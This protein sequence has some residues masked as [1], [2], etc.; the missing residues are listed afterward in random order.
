M[1]SSMSMIEGSKFNEISA[2]GQIDH[3]TMWEFLSKL[4]I[5]DFFE[6]TNTQAKVKMTKN[7]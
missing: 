4:A 7:Y 5:W 1:E 2:V 3:A 6:M